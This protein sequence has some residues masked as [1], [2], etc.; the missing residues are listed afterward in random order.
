MAVRSRARRIPTD[1]TRR[2]EAAPE[3]DRYSAELPLDEPP[4]GLSGDFVTDVTQLYLNDVGQHALL[5]P[6]EELALVARDA[7]GR[8]RGAAD[9]DRAQPAP[10]GQ[11][12]APLHASRRRAAGPD[13]GRQPRPHPR[14]REVRSRARLPLHD[15]RDVV[16]PAVDRARDHE[17]VAHDPPARARREGAQCRAARAAPSRDARA[18]RRARPVARGR[19]APAR[20]AG[21]RR[22]A[23]ARP[24]GAHALAR[25]ADRPRVGADDRRRHRRR[26][27]ARARAPAARQRDRSVGRRDG[28]PSSTRAS[29]S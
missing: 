15:V 7:R 23:P 24:P 5:T 18:A 21:R 9:D 11:H 22:R 27:G 20:Q 14:A 29:G 16:D 1:P 4:P 26:R 25:R 10:R 13:R 6:A 28:S 3:P 17:P 8:L 19:R 2:D 12:R